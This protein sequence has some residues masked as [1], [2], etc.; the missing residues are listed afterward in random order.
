M[1]KE[2]LVVIDKNILKTLIRRANCFCA[3]SRSNFFQEQAMQQKDFDALYLEYVEDLGIELPENIC[4]FEALDI[5]TEED[6]DFYEVFD[7]DKG[8]ND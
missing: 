6:L 1:K 4:G 2:N 8:K 3:L 7:Y 5:L